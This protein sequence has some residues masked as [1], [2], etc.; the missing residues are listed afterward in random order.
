LFRKLAQQMG[1]GRGYD[2]QFL[3]S[4]PLS[5]ARAKKFDASY[6][7]RANYRPALSKP[8]VDALA[9]VCGAKPEPEKG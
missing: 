5:V 7:V 1:E 8:E 6:D 9:N 3:Q 2:A 4:H